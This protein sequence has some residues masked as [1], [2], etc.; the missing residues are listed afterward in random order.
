MKQRDIEKRRSSKGP[1]IKRIFTQWS[2]KVRSKMKSKE[3]EKLPKAAKFVLS[4]DQVKEATEN[5]ADVKTYTVSPRLSIFSGAQNSVRKSPKDISNNRNLDKKQTSS[6]TRRNSVVEKDR[7]LN[8]EPH[9]ARK[10]SNGNIPNS[11]TSAKSNNRSPTRSNS[12]VEKDMSVRSNPYLISSSPMDVNVLP[13]WNKQTTEVTHVEVPD[14]ESQP[15]D[16]SS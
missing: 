3:K 13:A 1:D 12:V 2:E 6:P 5:K 14:K 4:V 11:R 15:P 16:I 10:T 8:S 9:S 7:Q